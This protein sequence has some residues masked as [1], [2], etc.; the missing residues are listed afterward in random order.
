MGWRLVELHAI[1][2]NISPVYASYKIF[3]YFF[4]FFAGSLIGSLK[5]TTVE[6]TKE[7][8]DGNV[9]DWSLGNIPKAV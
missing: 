7:K 5:S 1:C 8:F 9:P 2:C 4:L 6:L 3:A